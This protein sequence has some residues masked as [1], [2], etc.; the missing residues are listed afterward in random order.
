[1]L[2]LS[3]FLARTVGDSC[4]SRGS[5]VEVRRLHCEVG[6]CS[7]FDNPLSGQAL[8][9]NL[10]QRAEQFIKTIREEPIPELSAIAAENLRA[11]SRLGGTVTTG[12]L[13]LLK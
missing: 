7:R 3:T 2:L 8:P 9:E 13:H 12:K 11:A 4:C 5:S 10:R 6:S 1:M